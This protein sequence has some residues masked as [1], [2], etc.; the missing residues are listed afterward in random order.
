MESDTFIEI[1]KQHLWELAREAEKHRLAN[2]G[3]V[4]P[5][6]RQ[7]LPILQRLFQNHARLLAWLGKRGGSQHRHRPAAQA[8]DTTALP[9]GV[10]TSDEE[11]SR[12][13]I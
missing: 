8:V 12:V 6:S 11:I 3:R 9:Y 5:P 7:R 1:A 2:S 10:R 4:R 13:E